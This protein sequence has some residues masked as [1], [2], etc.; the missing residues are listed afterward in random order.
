[1][2]QNLLIYNN[3]YNIAHICTKQQCDLGKQDKTAIR[4]IASNKDH[5][6]FTYRYL[7]NISNKIANI[8]QY[9]EI[10]AGDRVFI[11]LP[12]IPDLYFIFLGILK[13]LAICGVLFSSF[14]EEALLD[15]LRDSNAKILFTKKSYLRKIQSIWSSLPSL[16]K[17]IVIDS[18]FDESDNILSFSKLL[19]QASDIYTT[20]L[21]LLQKP[22]QFCIIRQV[23]QASLK[24]FFMLTVVLFLKLELL[25]VFLIFKR[26]IFI[27]V[28][29][30]LVG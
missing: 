17:I 28:Q 3:Q 20:P 23:L 18:E 2:E 14:G 25:L 6:D 8:L 22:L 11:Y 1:M 7:E 27:G 29:Q 30:I 10:E 26:M 4:W 21:L 12:R 24:V 9:L 13:K 15:R 5:T 19:L 16:E